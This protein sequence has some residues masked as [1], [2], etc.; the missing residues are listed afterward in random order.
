[1]KL[2][3]QYDQWLLAVGTDNATKGV[4][5]SEEWINLHFDDPAEFAHLYVRIL[6][7]AVMTAVAENNLQ[8]AGPALFHY[9]FRF[10]TH[11]EAEKHTPQ[12]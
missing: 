9:T 5:E 10:A 6:E 8:N 7:Y 12:P 4:D 2:L 1:M 11:L 3:E